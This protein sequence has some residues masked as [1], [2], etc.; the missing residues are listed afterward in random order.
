MR[1]NFE[2][3]AAGPVQRAFALLMLQQWGGERNVY[4]RVMGTRLHGAFVGTLTVLAGPLSI[5]G[6]LEMTLWR[7]LLPATLLIAR[8]RFPLSGPDD[9]QVD[10]LRACPERNEGRRLCGFSSGGGLAAP[11][12]IAP[13][14][15]PRGSRVELA[16]SRP[17]RTIRLAV[18]EPQ[19]WRASPALHSHALP[20]VAANFREISDAAPLGTLALAPLPMGEG[21]PRGGG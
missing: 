9:E 8:S 7:R 6:L 10:R 16:C 11:H 3:R 19:G 17:R 13:C 2:P 12:W 15:L 20:H 5:L 4:R 14:G 21:R 18:E 1:R